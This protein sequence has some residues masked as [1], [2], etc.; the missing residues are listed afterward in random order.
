MD[1]VKELGDAS[2]P[3][4]FDVHAMIHSDNAPALEKE[5]HDYFEEHRVNKINLRKEFFTVSIAQIKQ[6]VLERGFDVQWTMKADALEY[7]Q[8]N[9][10]K[11]K[12]CSTLAG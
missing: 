5:L 11:E 4:S 7:R 10:L 3:F 2:V 8:T 9:K 6:V 1:R 12:V